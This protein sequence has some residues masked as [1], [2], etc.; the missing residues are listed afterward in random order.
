MSTENKTAKAVGALF[1]ITM[2]LGMIDAYTAAPILHRP[3]ADYIS[4][5]SQFYIGAFSILFMSLGVVGIAI[6]FYP[7]L[8]K[9]NRLI[10][11]TYICSRVMEYLLLLTGVIIY[12]FLLD[13]SREFI[14]AGS[15]DS[16]C[17]QALAHVAVEVRY[18]GYHV[19][20]TILSLASMMLCFL[21]YRTRLIPRII[22]A[23]GIIGYALVFASAPLDLLGI[24]DTTGS[25]GVLYVPGAL[26]ELLLL[27]IWLFWKGFNQA[28]RRASLKVQQHVHNKK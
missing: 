25:G 6:L 16:S 20:M 22:S 10:A 28:E 23:V 8:E 3:L 24:I 1:I 11:M 21:L 9:H 18:S 26:F 5:K 12:F 14:R 2:I 7:I 27:P 13:L 17:F 15:P 4:N 19:A